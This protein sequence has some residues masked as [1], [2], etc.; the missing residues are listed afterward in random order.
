MRPTGTM[1][2]KE[3]IYD[4]S[5]PSSLQKP[6]DETGRPLQ[7][8]TGTAPRLNARVLGWFFPRPHPLQTTEGLFC[9]SGPSTRVW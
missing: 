9:A 6:E 1:A 3:K 4:V 2:P 7:V 8:I 5:A